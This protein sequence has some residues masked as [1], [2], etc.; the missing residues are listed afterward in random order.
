MMQGLDYLELRHQKKTIFRYCDR[1]NEQLTPDQPTTRIMQVANTQI[2]N[3]SKKENPY[4]YA[5]TNT[6][7][8]MLSTDKTWAN[9]NQQ[10]KYD[11]LNKLIMQVVNI[12]I[13]NPTTK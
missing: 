12:Q 11:G 1:Q 6:H 9:Q 13:H 3:P 8:H 10:V 4:T 5:G 2:D 7:S